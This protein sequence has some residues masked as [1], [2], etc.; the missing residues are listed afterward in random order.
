[1]KLL[2]CFRY[3]PLIFVLLMAAGLAFICMSN[4]TDYSNGT[5]VFSNQGQV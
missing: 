3:L 4:G 2:R 1:M 5:F